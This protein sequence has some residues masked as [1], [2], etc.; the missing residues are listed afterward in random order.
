MQKIKQKTSGMI[1]VSQKKTTRRIARAGCIVV[2]D[3]KTFERILKGDSPKGDVVQTARV[4]GIMAAKK[5]WEIIPMCHPLSLGKV[6]LD[7]EFDKE[8]HQIT[9]LSEV[10]CRGKT[11]VEME[12]LSAAAIAALTIYDMMKWSDRRIEISDLKLQY[13]SG[14]KS[15]IFKR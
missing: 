3:K 7:F 13:K 12:A 5:T 2:T 4:A 6:S 9:V 15:G 8:K 1:D 10:V 14:G 11:G